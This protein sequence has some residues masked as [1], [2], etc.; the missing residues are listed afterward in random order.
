MSTSHRPGDAPLAVGIALALTL[1]LGAMLSLFAW[2][3]AR[4]APND[5]PVAVAGPAAATTR[6]GAALAQARPDAFVVTSVATRDDAARM[7]RQHE[8]YGALVVSTS[9]AEVLTASARSPVVAQLLGQTGAQLAAAQ[10]TTATVTDLVPLPADDPRGAGLAA[11]LLPIVLGGL[12]CASATSLLIR[13]RRWR[14][15]AATLYAVV[16]GFVLTALLQSWLGSLSGNLWANAAVLASGV[17]AVAFAVLGLESVF[18]T[19]G[20]G[21]GAVVMMLLGNALSGA[22]SAPE[23]LPSGWG[24]VG[25][26]LPAGATN[27]ALRAVAFFDG[28]GAAQPLLVLAAWVVFGLVLLA[29]PSRRGIPAPAETVTTHPPMVTASHPAG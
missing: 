8:V 23:L 1:A 6:M 4:L 22:G 16:G 25:Q 13:R 27:T 28:H 12:A 21:L 15:I 9:G 17:A 2:P 20:L 24:A 11:G 3:A 10:G 19:K 5:L 7:V 14:V 26:W 29:L 18:G